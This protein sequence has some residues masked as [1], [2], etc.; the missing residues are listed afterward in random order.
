SSASSVATSWRKRTR[1]SSRSRPETPTSP[2]CTRRADRNTRPPAG[3]ATNSVR[4]DLPPPSTVPHRGAGAPAT[5]H[6]SVEQLEHLL[7]RTAD[8]R[9]IA[10]E[11]HGPLHQLGMFEEE[12]DNLLLRLV[13]GGGQPELGEPLVV[14]DERRRRVGDRVDDLLEVGSRRVLLQV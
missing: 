6:E 10:A 5:R 12:R 11:P 3:A 9:A 2:R 14:A 7:A 1:P 4:V 13:V 8:Q